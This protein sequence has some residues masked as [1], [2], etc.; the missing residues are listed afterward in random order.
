[1]MQA[2][3]VHMVVYS[4]TGIEETLTHDND[5]TTPNEIYF[6]VDGNSEMNKT[7]STTQPTGI[8]NMSS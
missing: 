2:M 5:N 4:I 7:K 1:M 8:H 3:T 6:S